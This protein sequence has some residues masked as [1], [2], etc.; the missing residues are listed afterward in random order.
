M[1]SLQIPWGIQGQRRGQVL[2]L[3]VLYGLK[4]GFALAQG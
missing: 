3:R 2:W 1:P 4:V